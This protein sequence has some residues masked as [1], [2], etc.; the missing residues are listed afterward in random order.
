MIVLMLGS[1]ALTV[2]MTLVPA[3][4]ST[5][6]GLVEG[7]SGITSLATRAQQREAK[8][9]QELAVANNRADNLARE[10]GD[11]NVMYRGRKVVMREAVKDTSER[12]ARRTSIAAGRNIATTAGEAIPFYGIAVVVAATAWELKDACSLM[13]EMRE[14]DAAFNPMDAISDSEV[15]GMRMPTRAEIWEDVKSSPAAIKTRMRN[16]FEADA[17]KE[18]AP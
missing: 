8:L 7:V 5:V 9:V 13:K 18:A 16:L 2:A 14:L 11:R 15:C 4:F 6:A 12:V 17:T 3:V 10:L 1:F